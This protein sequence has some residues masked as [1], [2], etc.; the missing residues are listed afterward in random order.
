M[1]ILSHFNEYGVIADF[2]E[3]LVLWKKRQ[4]VFYVDETPIRVFKNNKQ[5]L[6]TDYPNSQPVGIFSTIWNGENWA[7][8]DG[9]VK[10]NW[11]HAPSLPPMRS[12]V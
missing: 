10:L 11:T 6:G 12:L 3:Y 2:Y 1:C 9:W 5:T 8:N 4:I 7:T